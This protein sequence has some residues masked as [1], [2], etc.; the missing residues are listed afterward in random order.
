MGDPWWKKVKSYVKGDSKMNPLILTVSQDPVMEES[1][2]EALD[3]SLDLVFSDGQHSLDSISQHGKPN[4]IIGD[5][6]LIADSPFGRELKKSDW[7]SIPLLVVSPDA[8]A[9]S[10]KELQGLGASDQIR[11]P[12]NTDEIKE[13]IHKFLLIVYYA[14]L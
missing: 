4:L 13:K 9:L 7:S 11:N 6:R 1:L 5:A 2:S 14:I 10:E 12:Y 8:K 3:D